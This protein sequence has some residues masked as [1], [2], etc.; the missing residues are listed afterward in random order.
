MAQEGGSIV[1]HAVSS[2]QW[3]LVLPVASR[4]K[5]DAAGLRAVG[6]KVPGAASDEDMVD[7]GALGAGEEERHACVHGGA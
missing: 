1:V 6:E 5:S 2:S 3:E 7:L 4:K